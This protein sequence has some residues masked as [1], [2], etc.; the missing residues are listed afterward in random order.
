M[1]S[2]SSY[3]SIRRS[4]KGRIRKRKG[5]RMEGRVNGGGT[6]EEREG[7]ESRE[8]ESPLAAREWRRVRERVPFPSCSS[9]S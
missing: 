6:G 5:K 3:K 1:C 7:R 4:R 2:K 8:R 9:S